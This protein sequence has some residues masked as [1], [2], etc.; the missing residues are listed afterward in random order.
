M[1]FPC[2]DKLHAKNVPKAKKTLEK[3]AFFSEVHGGRVAT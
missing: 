3:W 1:Q 2:Q